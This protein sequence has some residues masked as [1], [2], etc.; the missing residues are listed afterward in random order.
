MYVCMCV[1]TYMSMYIHR[2]A[3]L[4]SR[5]RRVRLCVTLQTLACQAPLSMGFSRQEYWSELPCPP[6]GALPDPGIEL[7]SLM[8]PAL[9][10]AFFTTSATWKAQ[11]HHTSSLICLTQVNLDAKSAVFKKEGSGIK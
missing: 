5:F 2:H 7:A 6:P 11:D 9:A 1:C 10:G 8:S 4:L 3:L